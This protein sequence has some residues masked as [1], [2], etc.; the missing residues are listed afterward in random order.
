MADIV[1]LAAATGYMTVLL[2]QL[3][4]SPRI[5]VAAILSATAA[6]LVLSTDWRFVALHAPAAAFLAM[7]AIS[8]ADSPKGLPTRR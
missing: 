2:S 3:P 1:L 6:S 4:R 7:V 8:W 5:G